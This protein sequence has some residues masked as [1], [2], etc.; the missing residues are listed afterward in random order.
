MSCVA[1]A[2]PAG[3][4]NLFPFRDGE[5]GTTIWDGGSD[6]YDGGNQLLVRAGG[7]WTPSSLSYTQVCDGQRPD[8][9][10]VEDVTYATCKLATAS[11][12]A[13]V[14]VMSSPSASID[15][16]VVRGDAGADGGGFKVW[17]NRSNPLVSS[18]TPGVYGFYKQIFGA[19]SDPSVNHLLI[20]KSRDVSI[21]VDPSTNSDLHEFVWSEGI[22]VLYYILWAGEHGYQYRT[23]DVQGVLDRVSGACFLGQLVAPADEGGSTSVLW[24]VLLSLLGLCGSAVA[25]L[26]CRRLGARGCVRAMGS[27]CAEALTTRKRRPALATMEANSMPLSPLSLQERLRDA[28]PT[29][30]SITSDTHLTMGRL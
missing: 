21:R 1:S 27:M 13:F 2:W 8:A 5:R 26:A 7:L 17:N 3:L 24:P 4:Y 16:F 22:E 28:S 20:T 29:S 12:P 19:G 11:G 30:G 10:G 23:S 14:A 15:G 9:A 18:T 25:L 6:M